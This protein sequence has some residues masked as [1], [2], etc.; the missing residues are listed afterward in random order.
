MRL[1]W[2]R[3]LQTDTAHVC[4]V[5]DKGNA[6]PIC[7]RIFLTNV[8]K[9]EP[10]EKKCAECV[11]KWQSGEE[12]AFV[13]K[14]GRKVI[15]RAKGAPNWQGSLDPFQDMAE[16]LSRMGVAYMLV[17]A[18]QGEKRTRYWTNLAGFGHSGVKTFREQASKLCDRVDEVI[19]KKENG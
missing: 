11:K 18:L 5:D 17:V 8:V 9:A 10:D 12:I 15:I 19:T 6:A 4:I 7:D 1:D 2:L 13:A 14:D 16:Q 3:P